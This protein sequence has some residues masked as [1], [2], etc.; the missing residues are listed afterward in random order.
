MNR[1]KET[2]DPQD[3]QI[4]LSMS[5]LTPLDLM[6]IRT[7]GIA[8]VELTWQAKHADLPDQPETRAHCNRV[9]DEI[10]EAG[11]EIVSIHIPYG[12][13][14][15]ISVMDEQEREHIRERIA[16]LFGMARDWGVRRAILHPSYEPIAPEGRRSRLE[17]ARDSLRR[18]API[19]LACGV[20][21][22][23]E[24]LPRTCLGNSADEI[25]ELIGVDPS[26]GVC[27][28]VNHLFKESPEDFIRRLGPRIV[29]THISDNDGLD[30]KHWMPG[31]GILN[32]KGILEAL[33]QSGYQGPFLYEVRQP[34]PEAIMDNWRAIRLTGSYGR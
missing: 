14:W 6:E 28:D 4:G 5:V 7:S 32:W 9:V 23:V 20:E 16:D 22:A 12:H 29:T 13:A 31:E 30:E 17:Y 18:L 34:I 3:W 25:E 11:I 1:K 26:L 33:S 8:C 15:D 27:C 10:R 24:C 21:I 2:T 19:A